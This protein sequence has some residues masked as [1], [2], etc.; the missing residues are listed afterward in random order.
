VSNSSVDFQYR[1]PLA[2]VG[3]FF[4]PWLQIILFG[5]LGIV[6]MQWAIDRQLE[7][8]GLLLFV[9]FLTAAVFFSV[10]AIS[11]AMALL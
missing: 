11:L 5:F 2:V 8:R 3:A 4:P 9:I 6:L 7:R 1:D 10:S